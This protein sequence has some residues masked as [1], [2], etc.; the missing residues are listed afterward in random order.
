MIRAICRSSLDTPVI[1]LLEIEPGVE[2]IHLG[3][4]GCGMR[5]E[6]DAEHLTQHTGPWPNL[7]KRRGKFYTVEFLSTG[8]FSP[9]VY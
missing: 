4:P 7:F 3:I 6:A 1:R 2:T 5:Y 8:E 9:T